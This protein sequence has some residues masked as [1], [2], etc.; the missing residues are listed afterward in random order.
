[1]P[2]RPIAPEEEAPQDG[3][4]SPDHLTLE[5]QRTLR[6]SRCGHVSYPNSVV[7][8]PLI[9]DLNG[10]G[11]QDITYDIVWSSGNMA[12]PPLMMAVGADLEEMFES[13]YGK[14]ILDFSTFVLPEKQPWSQYMGKNADN[15]FKPPHS[16]KP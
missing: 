11:H 14:G 12:A 2:Q 3:G 8:T 15:N 5:M 13:A 6:A 4:G 1:M 9:A 16:V 10:D 7:G